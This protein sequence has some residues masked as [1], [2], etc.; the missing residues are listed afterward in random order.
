MRLDRLT[1]KTREA[2]LSAQN[3]A[4]QRGN[5]ELYPEHV[6][7]AM[8]DQEGG[9]EVFFGGLR[10]QRLDCRARDFAGDRRIDMLTPPGLLASLGVADLGEQSRQST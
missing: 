6:L 5:P 3:D 2:L 10:H 4:V 7:A 8:L 1:N 9:V